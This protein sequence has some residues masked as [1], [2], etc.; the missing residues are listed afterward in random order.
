MAIQ[1]SGV[2]RTCHYQ[3]D[4][5]HGVQCLDIMF[6]MVTHCARIWEHRGH[7]LDCSPLK[8][9]RICCFHDLGHWSRGGGHSHSDYN[10]FTK[11]WLSRKLERYI[12]HWEKLNYFPNLLIFMLQHWLEYLGSIL[13]SS[14]PSLFKIQDIL[15]WN[16]VLK[17][18]RSSVSYNLLAGA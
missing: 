3:S 1:D 15:G 9:S 18:R 14:F 11:T 4:L 7:R 13:L 16:F 12:A 6:I 2:W 10:I 5:R 8:Q 17:A